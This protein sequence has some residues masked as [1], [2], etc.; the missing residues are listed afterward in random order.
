M[1]TELFSQVQGWVY[2]YY[3]NPIIYDTGYNPVNTATWAI[4]L[5]AMILGLIKLF[6]RY[7]LLVDSRF[8]IC[9][10]P[11]ILAG[12]SLRVIEDA[13]LVQ[14]P[15]RYLLI[16]PLIYFL[17]FA[18]T[19]AALIL[20]KK[21]FGRDF[22]MA[23][24]AVGMIWAGAEIAVLSRIGVSHPLVPA[25]ILVLGT[26]VAG[27]IYLLRL[28]IP[29]LRF[30]DN[31]CNLLVL[32]SHML[33]ASSTFVGVDFFGYQEKHVVPTFLIEAAGTAAVM[34]PLKLLVILPVLSV[35]DQTLDDP[36]LRNLT[37]LALVVLGLAPAVR[38][39]LR[40]TLGI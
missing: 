2:E 31:R 6:K 26:A 37:K 38:N 40:L 32:Y 8:I 16:T 36:S 24:G 30:L 15:E 12:S 19:S 23:Y 18:G 4:I 13:N 22:Y 25:A 34:Y 10:V 35:I 3:I 39:T 7:D 28:K 1:S 11:Y 27:S 33:D 5:G 9:T 17:M 29:W 14:A 21:A 20:A